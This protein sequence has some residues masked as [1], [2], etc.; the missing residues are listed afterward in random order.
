[1]TPLWIICH[2]RTGSTLLSD[3]LS[4]TGLFP[5][6]DHPNIRNKMG[7]LQEGL[8]FN[9]WLRLYTSIKEFEGHPPPYNK[10]IYHQWK[11]LTGDVATYNGRYLESI[12][13]GIR[14]IH[15]RRTNI[16]EHATSIYFARLLND[17]CREQFKESSA[18]HIY[19][20]ED[21]VTYFGL[22]VDFNKELAMAAWNEVLAY[23]DAWKGFAENCLEIT[24]EDLMNDQESTLVKILAWLGFHNNGVARRAVEIQAAR[25]RTIS[26]QRPESKAY[27][28]LLRHR[29]SVSLLM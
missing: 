4:H 15:L 16:P 21:L 10:C 22:E 5:A 9:E 20:Q 2:P 8:A 19:K 23:K 14:F 13:P 24:F 3:L 29:F 25:P 27:A 11:E 26:M 12:L 6:F 17:K 1:M 7:K 28:S 18:Y